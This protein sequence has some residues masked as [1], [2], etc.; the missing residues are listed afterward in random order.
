[1]LDN[2]QEQER[3]KRLR[4]KQLSARDPHVKQRQFQRTTAE[5]ERNRD[6]SYTLV[7]FWRD[8]PLVI[9]YALGGFLLAVVIVIFLPFFWESEWRSTVSLL[10]VVALTA[11]GGVVG[12]AVTTREN[13]KNLMR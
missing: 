5:R 8:I 2:N 12:N 3:L 6:R 13:I 7:D 11:F 9:R 4:E 10:I 1:M